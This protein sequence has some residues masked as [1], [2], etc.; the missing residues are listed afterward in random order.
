MEQVKD[1]REDGLVL[2]RAAPVVFAWPA[3]QECVMSAGG[4]WQDEG[5]AICPSLQS[6]AALSFASVLCQLTTTGVTMGCTPGTAAVP[7]AQSSGAK[8]HRAGHAHTQIDLSTRILWEC[9]YFVIILHWFWV[10]GLLILTFF[11]PEIVPSS[12][13]ASVRNRQNSCD[14]VFGKDNTQQI[15]RTF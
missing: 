14:N 10:H 7:D 1:V 4:S 6:G 3:G 2:Q 11:L 8:S 13:E 12:S 5:C 9:R 15:S